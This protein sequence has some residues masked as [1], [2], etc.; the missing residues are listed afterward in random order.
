MQNVYVNDIVNPCYF[1][2]DLGKT[3]MCNSCLFFIISNCILTTK[4][5]MLKKCK[6]KFQN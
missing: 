2:T 1:I 3:Y 6:L 4:L 5:H